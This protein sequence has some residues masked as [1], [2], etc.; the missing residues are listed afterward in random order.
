MKTQIQIRALAVMSIA[1]MLLA[2]AQANTIDNNWSGVTG[3]R[4]NM[5]AFAFQADAGNFPAS[6]TPVGSLTPVI[7]LTRLTFQ[8]PN[9][10]TTPSFG[11]GPRQL[12]DA[13]TPVFLDVYTTMTSGAF[14]GYL[15][16]SS[17]SVTWA[18]TVQDQAYSFDFSGLT[19]SSSTKYWFVFSEDNLE[20]DDTNFRLKLNTSGDDLTPGQGKGYLVNDT[21]QSLTS[22]GA[23]Q[24]WAFAF[25]AEFT[26][27][28]EPTSA[29]L[30]GLALT[31]WLVR[32]RCRQ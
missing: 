6:I 3:D 26:P 8:R 19:L 4:G 11:T 30:L 12:T 23:A 13:D 24:D 9:D 14:S 32:R 7:E 31:G 28:P 5:T 2:A 16:S 20:G 25:T 1:P 22:S 27:V 17:S 18:S 21:L 15:G 29:T 10:S